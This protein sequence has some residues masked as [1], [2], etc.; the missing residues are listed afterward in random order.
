MPQ[1]FGETWR[2]TRK[3]YN[4]SRVSMGD[5]SIIVQLSI[6]DETFMFYGHQVAADFGFTKP[7]RVLM[8]YKI[9]KNIFSMSV[10]P[11]WKLK[12]RV[13]NQ[14]SL[15]SVQA[16]T[17]V[18]VNSRFRY[19]DIRVNRP[20]PP[21]KFIFLIYPFFAFVTGKSQLPR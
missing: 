17:K 16:M 5:K 20:L 10:L 12:N 9:E 18:I 4:T 19:I 3:K 1:S 14:T 8:D 7:T 6:S 13:Q 2:K 11:M 21:C 15:L